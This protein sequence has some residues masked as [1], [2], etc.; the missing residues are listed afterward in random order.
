M[1]ISF[2]L[3]TLENTYKYFE[4]LRSE[5]IKTKLAAVN[6]PSNCNFKNVYFKANISYSTQSSSSLIGGSLYLINMCM[7]ERDY[8]V[9]GML[10]C[11]IK[12]YLLNI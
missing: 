4:I 7:H 5:T 12:S 8:Q 10:L 2:F 9:C 1:R 11:Y 6:M 3:T